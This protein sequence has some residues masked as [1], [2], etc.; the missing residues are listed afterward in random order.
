MLTGGIMTNEA[1]RAKREAGLREVRKALP[2]I[3]RIQR[4]KRGQDWSGIKDCPI[5]QKNLFVFHYRN[6]T[7]W[8]KCET[9]DCISW[10]LS[11]LVL[12]SNFS[13]I[14]EVCC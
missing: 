8:G 6:G 14:T 13:L 10:L 4:E 3:E 12:L 1:K 11:F 7:Y 2:L 5:C 9:K